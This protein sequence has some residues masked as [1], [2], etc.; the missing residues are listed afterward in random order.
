MSNLRSA[1][2]HDRHPANCAKG[3][4]IRLERAHRRFVGDL[5]DRGVVAAL[6][7]PHGR[8]RQA[9]RA[10]QLWLARF[11]ERGGREIELEHD[12]RGG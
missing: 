5:D 9:E 4:E 10:A 12:F 11:A 1:R 8:V 3:G 6:G 7:E 2:S